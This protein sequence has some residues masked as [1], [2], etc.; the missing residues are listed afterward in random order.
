MVVKG[1]LLSSRIISWTATRIYRLFLLKIEFQHTGRTFM[2][3]FFWV[4]LGDR[5]MGM[6]VHFGLRLDFI[7]KCR[8]LCMNG[9]CYI[10]LECIQ[11]PRSKRCSFASEMQG[12]RTFKP[13]TSIPPNASPTLDSIFLPAF[14]S[15]STVRC[16]N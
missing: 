7:H 15:L 11:L 16:Q 5:F 4:F 6:V 2:G 10:L 9:F 3:R 12:R 8:P 1:S 14:L 13:T